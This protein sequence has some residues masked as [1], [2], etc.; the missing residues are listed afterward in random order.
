M[1]I[2]IQITSVVHIRRIFTLSPT[3]PA[4]MGLD[5][6][7]PGNTK[8]AKDTA[9]TAFKAFV[10]GEH[11][12]FDYVK[13]CIEQDAT[14]KCF[15]SVL[16]KFGMY[17][18]FNEVRCG[19]F[20]LFPVQRHIVE[21]KLLSMGKTLDSFCMKRD[22]KVVNKASLCSKSAL[23]KMMMYLH[24]NASSTSDYQD[25]TLLCQLWNLFGRA[26][27]LSL[28]RKQNFSVDAG[29]VFFVRFIRMESSEEQGL[30]LF[31]D[32]DFVTC[33]LHAIAIAIITQTAPTV[34]LIDN[35]PDAPVATAV[36]MSPSTPLLEVLN[37][38]EEF[39]A[40]EP[41]AS[42]ARTS[43][44][45]VD[46]TPTIY[47][48]VNR[49]LDRVA[50]VAGVSDALT[51]HSFRQGG[52]Q[53][54][55]GCDGLTQRWMFDRGGAQQTSDSITSSI[56]AEKITSKALSGYD[57]ETNVKALD[58]KPFDTET[59]EKIADVQRLLFTTCYRMESAKYNLSQQVLDVLTAYLILQGD[60]Q[61][62]RRLESAAVNAGAS[63]TELLAWPSHLA[64]CQATI[65]E[66]SQEQETTPI[67]E[68]SNQ[69]KIIDH[70]RSV[71]DQLMEH[72][73]CQDERKDNLEAKMNGT[74]SQDKNTNV[75][76]S[77]ISKQQKSDAK[78]LV[79]F[80]KI[81]LDG[82]F[83]LDATVPDYRDRVLNLG[84]RAEEVVLS[85]LSER[86]ITSRGAGNVLK[87]LRS[88]HRSGILN[89]KRLIQTAVI[90]DP[91]PGYTQDVLEV[92]SE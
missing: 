13:Q 45:P 41:S 33:P 22:G 86:K 79:A 12:E 61:A 64:V 43:R 40:L 5:E 82:G 74:S 73:K 47:T 10:K 52:A 56:Q 44:A 16:D 6:L 34:A 55:N 31:P 88:L 11:V 90:K 65:P 67:T 18:A 29:K 7:K 81:F 37:H 20:E 21:A 87:H 8:R 28:V 49:L 19:L 27:D 77:T 54:V 42:P 30:S 58:L 62:V 2:G 38:P 15:V 51:S 39:A 17:L 53:H 70:Q 69:S 24:E 78:L 48:H 85:F 80:M 91:A 36:N 50:R 84:K 60:G 63:V 46:T 14:G 26:S 9:V 23:K 75:S 32:A 76:E 35:L 83:D 59:L 66:T 4:S 71:I 25:A 57:T 1:Y 89:A 68:Q 72:I 92:I 3:S